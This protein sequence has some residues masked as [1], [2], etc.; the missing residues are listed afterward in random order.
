MPENIYLKIDQKI[1]DQLE[2][3][4]GDL[5][6]EDFILLI[7][8]E[9]LS[10]NSKFKFSK[11]NQ[12]SI[13]SNSDIKKSEL[14][15]LVDNLQ[16]FANDIYNKLDRLEGKL[17]ERFEYNSANN[18]LEKN[19]TK[20]EIISKHKP[21]QVGN[22][23]H[24]DSD[25]IFVF[26]DEKEESSV[27]EEVIFEIADEYKAEDDVTDSKTIESSEFEF[28][29]PYCNA[30]IPENA[31]RCPKC[32]NRFDDED[33]N[34][35]FVEV[36]PLSEGYSNSG[37]YDPRPTYIK[38]KEYANYG[39]KPDP[40]KIPPHAQEELDMRKPQDQNIARPV[41]CL[42]CGGKLAYI[43]DYKRWYCPRCNKY[44]GD[45]PRAGP[46]PVVAHPEQYRSQEQVGYG[47]TPEPITKRQ[48]KKPN[49]RPL[50]DYHRY[51]E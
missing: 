33:M 37:E 47:P 4:R 23:G 38:R 17:E 12:S 2:K 25:D 49:W 32:G 21:E 1:L 15:I 35:E 30:T 27:K 5:K 45:P 6:L 42:N 18:N 9:H 7:I 8:R 13:E 48:P 20:E 40:G 24:R 46:T 29:C 36:K 41:M 10:D 14:G 19:L 26:P 3:R 31:T 34:T 44:F 11:I 43:E 28:G 16:D 50:K 22:I 51:S 39:P